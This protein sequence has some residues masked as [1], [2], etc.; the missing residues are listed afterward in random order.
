MAQYDFGTIDPNTK[1]GTALASDLNSWRSA[2]H[3]THSGA[4]APSYLVAGMLWADTTSANYELKQYDG[5]QWI[6][7]AI[8]DATNNVA[9]VAVDPAET[10]YIT[11]TTNGQIRHLIAGSDILTIRSTGAQFNIA[12]PVI[13]DSNNNELVSFTTT[14]SAVN[15][16]NIT[17]AATTGA[18]TLSAAGGDTNIGITLASKGTGV[19]RSLVETSATNTVIDVAQIEARSTG[20]PAAGIGSG[21]LFA[22]ETAAGNFEIGARIDAITTDVTSTSEDFDLSFKVMAAGAAA[23]E[24]MRIRSTGVVDVDALSIAGTTITSTAAELNILDG[25]TSTAA[26]LNILDGVTATAAELNV[27]DGISG[28]AS[29]A[30]AEA[31]TATDKLM[32]PE[33]VSQAISALSTVLLGTLTTTS[34]S[35]QTLSGLVLTD[36]KF[37]HFTLNAVST[38][39]STGTIGLGPITDLFGPAAGGSSVSGMACV[40][41][42]NGVATAPTKLSA[43][44]RVGTGASGYSTATTS[45]SVNVSAGTFDAGSIRIYGV[46]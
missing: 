7:I 17:N 26:E 31:G 44:S 36:Y 33:R 25:V 27:L 40:D 29:Q 20:T 38:S 8:I 45:V 12:A 21:L 6:T 32:T 3:S 19:V 37:L 22:T 15:Q 43:D 13:A 42:G 35:V 30:E 41:L 24:V 11:S 14:A 2:L 16:L 34:G 5:A 28:I 23:V 46:K 1:S 10:S 18:P 39:G 9:R 4:T